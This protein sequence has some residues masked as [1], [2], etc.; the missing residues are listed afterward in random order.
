MRIDS[1][2]PG[3]VTTEHLRRA[4]VVY[5][6]QSSPTQVKNNEESTR[7]QRELRHKAVDLGW[8]E[9]ILIEDDLGESAS[10]FV[11]RPGF[12]KLKSWVIAGEVGIIFCLEISRLSRNSV[13]WAR[14][15]ELCQHF[16]TLIADTEQVYDLSLSNDRLLIGI[17]GS[18]SEAELATIRLRLRL[19][20]QAKA[21]RGE[22]WIQLPIGYVYD[23]TEIVFDPD[24]RIRTAI[25]RVFQD[26]RG[27]SS[28]RQLAL[29]YRDAGIEFPSRGLGNKTVRW[30]VPSAKSL[31]NL[32]VNPTYAGV[33][34]WGRSRTTSKIADGRLVKQRERRQD[35]G[36]AR[37]MIRDH[38]PAYID[39]SEYEANLKKLSQ[40]RPRRGLD[41]NRGAAREGQ[42]LLA[43]MLRCGHCGDQLK[44]RYRYE[45]AFYYCDGTRKGNSRI[46]LSV[47]ACRVDPIVAQQLCRALDSSGIE[48]ATRAFEQIEKSRADELNYAKQ[49]VEAAQYAASHAFEQFD[50]CDPRNRLV[51]DNLEKRLN[52]K[53]QRLAEAKETLHKQQSSRLTLTVAERKRLETLARN[54]QLVWRSTI[55]VRLKKTLLRAAIHEIMIKESGELVGSNR[56][57]RRLELTIHWK[58]GV[59]STSELLRFPSPKASRE[60]SVLELIKRLSAAAHSDSEIALV[61]NRRRLTTTRWTKDKVTEFRKHNGINSAQSSDDALSMNGASKYLGVSSI[62]LRTLVERG[63]IRK[64][65]VA[66]FAPWRVSRHELD[67]PGVRSLVATLKATGRFPPKEGCAKNQMTLFDDL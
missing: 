32:L 9:P 20:Q 19:G 12:E 56:Q 30:A 37:V 11:D 7:L 6:R 44:V 26:F 34:A 52:D 18:I 2:H 40:N 13:D 60:V 50:A 22:L 3:G 64:N 14:L 8:R 54:F 39:W 57:S 53:L 46:C 31:H 28:A 33:Y 17:R 47:G 42:A 45:K 29:H 27:S 59:H 63:L 38:H 51:A 58:G 23:D 41:G 21:K 43:G 35:P 1:N 24:E 49:Q 67:S 15:M 48:A 61:L 5:I 55:D 66:E 25:R 4:A 65:Q 62:A 16:N 36:E 10:G